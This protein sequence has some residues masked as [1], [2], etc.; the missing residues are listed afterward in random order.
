MG[1][2]EFFGTLARS[3]ITSRS[4]QSDYQKQVPVDHFFLDF[5]SIVYGASYG[6][7]SGINGLLKHV[8]TA[9]YDNKH[10]NDEIKAIFQTYKMP[11]M[12]KDTAPEKII[13]LFHEY[14]TNERVEHLVISEVMKIF[15][16]LINTYCQPDTIKTIMVALDGVP[17]KGKMVEQR[18]RRYLGAITEAY[19]KLILDDYADY[20]KGLPNYVYLSTKN[21]IT[22]PTVN[23]TPGTAFMEKLSQYL[24]SKQITELVQKSRRVNY[25]VSD[26]HE[27][28]EGEKKIVN[29]I[30]SLI[31]HDD[32]IMIYSP[33]ADVIL[34]CMLLQ[35]ETVY[36]LRHDQQVSER[37]RRN[38]YDLID[39]GALISN[40]SY[41]VNRDT[42]EFNER[43]IAHDIVCLST[44]FG[45]DFVPKIESI[46]IKNNFATIMDI[47]YK[48]VSELGEH[49]VLQD[50]ATKQ[51]ELNTT[52]L[53][54]IILKLLPLEQDFIDN[55]ALYNK[56]LNL[57]TIKMVFDYATINQNTLHTV[58]NGFMATYADLKRAL[59]NDEST[60]IFEADTDFMSALRKAL[61]V[62]VRGKQVN[63]ATLTDEQLMELLRN[64]RADEGN[65]PP[66]IINLRTRSTSIKDSFYQQDIK[67]KKLNAYEIERL[68]FQKMLDKYYY[69]FNAQPLD[70]SAKAIPAYYE[71]YFHAK[72]GSEEMRKVL[73][74]Y[75][76]GI[77]WVFNYYFNSKTYISTWYYPYERS[78]LLRDFSRF[79]DK[80]TDKE[81]DVLLRSLV[82]RFD[83]T[84]ITKYFNPLEQFVNVSP[85]TP[86]VLAT[87]P[88][89]YRDI[90]KT[91]PFF[92]SYF[93]D[94]DQLTMA[95]YQAKQSS[96]I[97]CRS[98]PYLN[99]CLFKAIGKTTRSEDRAFLRAIRQVPQTPESEK[100]GKNEVPSY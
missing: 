21:P 92:H 20:L 31:S 51:Y 10:F 66:L 63:T 90:E 80:V 73:Q 7:L 83:V 100:L 37:A 72:K 39:I 5:N 53:R 35:N 30:D 70:L 14:F 67:R 97:D 38:V 87:L 15:I 45:N 50:K 34:L 13:D 4:I 93:I 47:Y 89:N 81:M 58:Y 99:K 16:K 18:Q 88:S 40:I 3:N 95:L 25:V 56:Y 41:Y 82:T 85:R 32:S 36:M 55:N 78:P 27:I 61:N 28:G 57:G 91:I 59:D 65:Y 60:G 86:K 84:D 9:R 33:D 68:Q 64:Y 62:R 52:F 54:R 77:L 29:Y 8:L 12:P 71:T 79:L 74:S 43:S 17:S 42:S 98:I 96:E 6:V 23:I 46:S 76:E 22:W 75:L 24:H 19:E 44:I 69:K 26:T 49:L 2:I 94:I 48:T 1:V 11:I